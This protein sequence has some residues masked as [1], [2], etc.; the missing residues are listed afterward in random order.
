M[1]MRLS[2]FHNYLLPYHGYLIYR[3][4]LPNH[5]KPKNDLDLNKWIYHNSQLIFHIPQF[6]CELLQSYNEK[7][8][9]TYQILFT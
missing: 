2:S 8:N 7:D 3:S 1:G 5:N 4:I 6:F 9:F